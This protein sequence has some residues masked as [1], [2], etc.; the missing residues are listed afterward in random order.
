MSIETSNDPVSQGKEA[1]I[2]GQQPRPSMTL[3]FSF[4]L[5]N[6]LEA[7]P[8]QFD[9]FQRSQEP[10]VRATGRGGRWLLLP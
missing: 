5:P 7:E 10:Y 1:A 8:G 4:V 6:L 3:H 9:D 2:P